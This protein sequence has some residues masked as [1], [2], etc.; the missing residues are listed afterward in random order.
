MAIA[1]PTDR[2]FTIDDSTLTARNMTPLIVG[3]PSNVGAIEEAL[4]DFTGPGHIN[5]LILPAGFAKAEDMTVMFRAD[6]GGSSPVDPTAEFHAVRTGSRTVTITFKTGWTFSSESYIKN[7]RP[8]TP[9][10]L[11]SILE[12]VFVF[13]GD[14]TIT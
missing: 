10:M 8:K 6:V 4:Q 7:S 3:E 2:T 14:I 11:G 1:T 5:P 13:T 9:P 12:V